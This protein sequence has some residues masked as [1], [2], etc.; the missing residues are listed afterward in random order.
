MILRNQ[1][2][3]N[4]LK[5]NSGYLLPIRR[6]RV[7]G[8]SLMSVLRPGIRVSHSYFSRDRHVTLSVPFSFSKL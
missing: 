5:K 3:K 8:E 1:V 6:R 4:Y 2:E 7:I